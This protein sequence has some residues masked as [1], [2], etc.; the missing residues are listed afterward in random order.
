MNRTL[1][2]HL[3]ALTIPLV[4]LGCTVPGTRPAPSPN[5]LGANSAPVKDPYRTSGQP[6]ATRVVNVA[7]EAPKPPTPATPVTRAAAARRSPLGP[8][9]PRVSS[10]AGV[11]G[12][13]VL[14]W[15]RIV[16]YAKEAELR[17]VAA[18]LQRRLRQIVEKQL[19]GRAIDQRPEPERVCP[20]VGCAGVGVGVL[21]ATSK[22][23]CVAVAFTNQPGLSETQLAPWGGAMDVKTKTVAFRGKPEEAVTIRDFVPC[24]QLLNQ[25]DER[26]PDVE[27]LIRNAGR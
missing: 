14:L 11:A 21:L 5:E 13:V 8:A 7:P 1:L 6:E 3:A 12:G 18:G 2:G 19:P 25:L 20:G 9:G 17:P 15:P 22:G 27:L 16:P 4:I 23:G 26:Q 24:D 10:S